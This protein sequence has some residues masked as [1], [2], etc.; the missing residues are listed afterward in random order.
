[1]KRIRKLIRHSFMVSA[2]LLASVSSAKADTIVK[3]GLGQTGSDIIFQNGVFGTRDQ[4]DA[5]TVGDQNSGIEFTGFLNSMLTNIITGASVTISDV[6]STGLA[7][8][9]GG[10]GVIVQQTFG[11][12]ISIWDES[13]DLLLS[14]VLG[15]GSFAG[16]NGVPTGSFFNTE[17]MTYNGGSLLSFV[18]PS[19]GS[20]SLSMT[21]ILSAGNQTGF[22]IN[23]D[24]TLASF[25]ANGNGLLTGEAIPEPATVMLILSGLVG[26]A[27]K[28]RKAMVKL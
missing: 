17:V 9:S 28:R 1:M 13:N 25:T 16:A 14:G 12:L 21:S 22:H 2:V 4:G 8:D 19:P 10:I 24:G 5:S 11:G 6:V 7:T 15:A 26:G 18:A 23:P 3:F 20:I 27:I